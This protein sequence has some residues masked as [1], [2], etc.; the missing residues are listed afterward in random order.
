[1]FT[2]EK[3]RKKCFHSNLHIT[4]ILRR[5]LHYNYVQ[6]SAALNLPRWVTNIIHHSADHV[7]FKGFSFKNIYIEM[8]YKVSFKQI[9]QLTLRRKH[10]QEAKQAIFFC[11]KPSDHGWDEANKHLVYQENLTSETVPRRCS[12]KKVF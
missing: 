11:R 7:D 3:L 2:L 5:W 6:L 4:H 10:L 12:V 8:Y 9:Y 1:M